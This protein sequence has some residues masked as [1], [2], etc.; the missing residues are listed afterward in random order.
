M[1]QPPIFGRSSL[2]RPFFVQYSG[3]ALVFAAAMLLILPL[4][5]FI[6]M[7]AAAAVHELFHYLAIRITGN[8]VYRLSLTHYGAV[9]QTTPLSDLEELFCAF[10]GPIGSLLLFF[11]YPW[12]PRIS[13]CAGVQGIF[14][15]LPL[16]P[17]DG[18][19]IFRILVH[20]F[21][22][23]YGTTI[24][25]WTEIGLIAA[26]MLSGICFSAFL[27]LGF[28]PIFLSALLLFRALAEKFLA[29]RQN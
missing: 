28:G 21:F 14:N 27:R 1:V 7:I 12:I 16:Y 6:S 5:W 2:D 10:S 4:K 3:I 29:N 22:P 24:C 8:R 26:I 25:K 18:G 15:L 20:R 9:M 19:R 13:I 11:C 23:L 17:L